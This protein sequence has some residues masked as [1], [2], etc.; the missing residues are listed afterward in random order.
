MIQRVDIL[1]LSGPIQ[2]VRFNPVHNVINAII[3]AY[4]ERFNKSI[5]KFIYL[6]CNKTNRTY[7]S[8]LNLK[9][10][11]IFASF[12]FFCNFNFFRFYGP[13]KN[14]KNNFVSMLFFKTNCRKIN[15]LYGQILQSM[16]YKLL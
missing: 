7:E 14:I 8:Y 4:I 5:L 2:Q 10:A 11:L 16:F 9:T 15:L 13:I 1:F 3:N 12:D 6:L